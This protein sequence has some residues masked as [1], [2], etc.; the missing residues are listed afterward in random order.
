MTGHSTTKSLRAKYDKDDPIEHPED[1]DI[2]LD[3]PFAQEMIINSGRGKGDKGL[4]IYKRGEDP[5]NMSD[6]EENGQESHA[7]Q[8][9]F[10]IISSQRRLKL[11]AKN[12][13]SLAVNLMKTKLTINLLS[14]KCTSSSL[15]WSASQRNASGRVEID[16]T[17]SPLCV[18]MSL[19]NGL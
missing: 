16:S 12:A 13:V 19:H 10:Y 15:V 3:N 11:V 1:N 14:V 9:T 18:S 2:D 7:S 6:D 5:A 8:H 4:G 17:L